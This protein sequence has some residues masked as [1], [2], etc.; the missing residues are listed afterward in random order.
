MIPLTIWNRRFDETHLEEDSMDGS[1]NIY[2]TNLVAVTLMMTMGWVVSVI[3]RNV[4]I[5]D[6]LW[7]IGFMLIAWI[8]YGMSD[9]FFARKLLIALLVTAWGI[10]LSGYLAWRN[11]GKGEDPRYGA[12]RNNHGK[13]FWWVSLFKV[14]LIQ[15][16]FMWVIALAFQFG[17]MSPLPDSLTWLDGLGLIL[18]ITGFAFESIGDWQLARFKSV[19]ENAG[20][21]MDQGLW[22]YTRHPNYFGEALVWWGLSVMVLSTPGSLWTLISPII[23][24]VVLLKMTGVALTEKVILETRPEYRSYIERTSTFFPWPPKR[25]N[26][27]CSDESCREGHPA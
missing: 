21:V 12:W 24:T 19:P 17:M 9:G 8:T 22:T 18:W 7:G 14:F 2:L 4:T 5:V 20:K 1:L 11:H 15:A 27:E 16:V 26:N 23:I 10:R 25:R 3:R 13:R 6:T